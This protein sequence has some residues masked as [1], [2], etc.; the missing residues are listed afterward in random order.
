MNE[1]IDDF[2]SCPK[3]NG[4]LTVRT[5]QALGCDNGEYLDEDGINGDSWER[6]DE[7]MGHG[8][9]RWCKGC[10][11]DDVFKSFLS[12]RAEAEWKAKQEK[13]ARQEIICAVLS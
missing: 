1:W 8:Y 4:E 3:C 10:G 7:C 6:C 2:R 12:P 5:C 13:L 9:E 11:W